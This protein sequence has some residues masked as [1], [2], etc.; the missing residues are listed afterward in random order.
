LN[1]FADPDFWFHYG[2]LPD[3][4]RALADKSFALLK[5]NP[6]HS[7][8]RLKKIG[9]L[10]SARIGLHYRAL[11]RE[12]PDGLQWFW[13]GHHSAYDRLLNLR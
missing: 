10:Y 5:S 12:R 9:A 11:A 1:H 7:S 2:K 3:E 8:V 6:Q 13:I 4:V